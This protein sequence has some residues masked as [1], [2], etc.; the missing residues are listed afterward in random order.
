MVLFLNL[1]Q[2][3]I[4]IKAG[5]GA[6]IAL[7]KSIGRSV[8]YSN[9]AQEIW[10]VLDERYGVSS[11]AQLFGLHKELTEL[12]QGNKKIA[13]YFTEVKMLWG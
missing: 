13:D 1:I 11:G 2:H 12:T 6:M 5:L 8:I 4:P 7:S 3:I 9:S 10:K